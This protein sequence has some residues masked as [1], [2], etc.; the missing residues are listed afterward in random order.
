MLELVTGSRQRESQKVRDDVAHIGVPSCPT[1]GQGRGMRPKISE[2]Q[3][4][5]GLKH[6]S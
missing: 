3:A 4:K 5:Q 1:E 6:H 2:Y